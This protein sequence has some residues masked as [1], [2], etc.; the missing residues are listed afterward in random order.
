MPSWQLIAP[1]VLAVAVLVRQVIVLRAQ[2][3][4]GRTERASRAPTQLGQI[5]F[6]YL[7]G[8]PPGN[9]LEHG[10]RVAYMHDPGHL[11]TFTVPREVHGRHGLMMRAHAGYAIGY[12]IP[13]GTAQATRRLRFSVKYS[14]SSMLFLLLQ[15]VSPDR[16]WAVV[17]ELKIQLQEAHPRRPEQHP[18]GPKEDIVWV[19]GTALGEGWVALDLR[20]HHLVQVVWASEALQFDLLRGIRLRGDIAISPISLEQ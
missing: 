1:P 19:E 7:A 8:N 20:L 10:W 15:L 16:R 17:R 4:E 12:L 9:P 18:T 2:R 13:P 14:D 11:P 6:D 5:R 3:Y